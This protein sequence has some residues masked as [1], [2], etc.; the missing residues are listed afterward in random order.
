M[1]NLEA[2]VT[3][4]GRNKIGK[5]FVLKNGHLY[6]IQSSLIKGKKFTFLLLVMAV[7]TSEI[8]LVD[9]EHDKRFIVKFT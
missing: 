4:F 6:T 3:L 1:I 5:N 2:N 7:E 9:V 8:I